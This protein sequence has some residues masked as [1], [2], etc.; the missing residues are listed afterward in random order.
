MRAET[1][2]LVDKINTEH[3][4]VD[5]WFVVEKGERQGWFFKYY[6]LLYNP[7]R[8]RLAYYKA[9]QGEYILMELGVAVTHPSLDRLNDEK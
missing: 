9:R 1:K 8:S 6:L 5:T 4:D 2:L 7:K 3:L